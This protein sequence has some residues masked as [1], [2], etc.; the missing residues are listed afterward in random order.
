M[1]HTPH[2]N[3]MS[4]QL[5]M[6]IIEDLD[7]KAAQSAHEAAE[8]AQRKS[9]MTCWNWPGP[10]VGQPCSIDTCVVDR[11]EGGSIYAYMERCVMLELRADG[12]WLA[13][14]AMGDVDGKPWYKN[15][16]RVL[17]SVCDIWPPVAELS[18]LREKTQALDES[19]VSL[20]SA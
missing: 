16:M 18:L 17:L 8:Q 15:G 19:A 20:L 12:R 14:I 9:W 4:E 10:A 2:A 3:I 13:E 5:S 7:L 1:Y 11:E 6:G